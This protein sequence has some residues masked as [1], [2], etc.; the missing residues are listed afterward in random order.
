MVVKVL[1]RNELNLIA[2]EIEKYKTKLLI[3]IFNSNEV[4][5][6]YLNMLNI[7]VSTQ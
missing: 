4:K 3:I 6:S 2:L 1:K 5:N 7:D